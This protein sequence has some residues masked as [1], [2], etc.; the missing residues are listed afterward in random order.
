[1]HR[2][3]LIACVALL[4]LAPMS[5]F[6]QDGAGE[7]VRFRV[8]HFSP[9]LGNVDI[10]IRG[11]L[12]DTRNLSFAE[13]TGWFELTPGSYRFAVVPAGG[14]LTEEAITVATVDLE[15]GQWVTLG[16]IGEAVRG[17]VTL[18]PIVEDFS[19]LSFG[20]TRLTFFN[21][22]PDVGPINIQ[23]ADETLLVS[24]LQ[25]PALPSN[26]GQPSDGVYILDIL[27]G[28]RNLQIT[29]VDDNAVVLVQMD[30]LQLASGKNNLLVATGLRA[31]AVMVMVTTD[32]TAMPVDEENLE[33]GS[34]P[35]VGRL[36]LGHFSPDAGELDVY[37]NGEL[38]EITGLALGE[39]TDWSTLDAGRYDV[40]VVPTGESLGRALMTANDVTLRAGD[41]M[42]VAALGATEMVNSGLYPILEDHGP[43]ASGE[44]RLAFL[45]AMPDLG[46]INVQLTDGPLL[47]NSVSFP[48][49][50]PASDVRS[51]DIVAGAR[52]LEITPFDDPFD[53]ILAMPDV[54]LAEGRYHLLVAAGV[55]GNPLPFLFAATE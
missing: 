9:G 4:L 6:G 50:N 37:I 15:D 18:H 39:L 48:G 40:A 8:G 34:G 22:L 43:I 38:S 47:L 13:V 41:W 11:E 12:T 49:G 14:S 24:G 7:A 36:R 3:C 44:T 53:V 25:Y 30:D 29:P 28:T 31:S 54:N 23:I 1:M 51:L 32:P 5:A 33:T 19:P 17:T 27:A 45:H 35:G 2:I 55:R 42:T 46:P 52:S 16:L 26:G 21:A 10:Y 20:E